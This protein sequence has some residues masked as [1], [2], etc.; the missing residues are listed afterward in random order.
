MKTCT[1]CG[2]TKPL[3]DFYA[4]RGTCKICFGARQAIYRSENREAERQRSARHYAETRDARLEYARQRWPSVAEV[5]REQQK[6]WRENNRELYLET[7]RRWREENPQI[8]RMHRA[9]RR[10]RLAAADTQAFTQMEL[11]EHYAAMGYD[12]CAYC[13]GLYE[14]DDHIIPLF[15]GGTHTL[16]NLAPACAKCNLSKGGKY[17]ARWLGFT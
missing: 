8:L 12:G 2:E 6:V 1:K 17:L 14:H 5:R 15:R 11:L 10:G 7:Q 16:D 13:G 9:R 4:K 3:E